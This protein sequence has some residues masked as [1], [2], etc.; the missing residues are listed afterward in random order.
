MWP[1]TKGGRQ[2]SVREELRSLF[3]RPQELNCVKS[4]MCKPGSGSF[5]VE[6][7]DDQQPYERPRASRPS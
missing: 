3:N 7:Q 1:G 4:H 6:P 2:Q 5:P